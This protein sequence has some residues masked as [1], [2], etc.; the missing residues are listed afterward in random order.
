MLAQ[1]KKMGPVQGT[2]KGSKGS[3]WKDDERQTSKENERAL[4]L[5]KAK[6]HKIRKHLAC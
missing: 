3:G 5:K 6:E 2:S 1:L 4:V